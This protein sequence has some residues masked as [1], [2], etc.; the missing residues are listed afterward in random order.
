M[1]VGGIGWF[2][3]RAVE[4][5]TYYG[6]LTPS[7]DPVSSQGQAEFDTRKQRD[8]EKRH[9]IYWCAGIIVT[10]YL[11][12]LAFNTFTLKASA[13]VPTAAP[14]LTVT[15][16]PTITLTPLPLSPTPPPSD[17]F[18]SMGTGAPTG[19]AT[20]TYKPTATDRI[21]YLAGKQSVVVVTVIVE[22]QITVV[23]TATPI[24]SS[25]TPTQT[26]SPTATLTA[27]DT[28]TWTETPTSTPTEGEY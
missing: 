12:V 28:P 26:A 7:V 16:T 24:I 4:G 23:V 17:L 22:R 3:S 27:T 21:V 11:L 1:L 5:K 20:P 15:R 25:P 10:G 2:L 13:A 19:S 8:A 14:T 9:I 18:A 6:S